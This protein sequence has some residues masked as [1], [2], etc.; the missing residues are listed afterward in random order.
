VKYVLIGGQAAVISGA[1]L[2]TFDFDACYAR[3]TDNLRRL[4]AALRDLHARL[5]V[6][7]MSD[8]EAEDLPF[9]IDETTLGSGLNFTFQ[10][11]A[12]AVD[13]LGLPAGV[14]GYEELIANAVAREIGGQVVQVASIRDLISMKQASGREKDL[15][16]LPTLL[17]LLDRLDESDDH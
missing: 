17:A 4:A 3:D 2:F 15:F 12:G 9:H 7:K 1:P 8:E 10:T 14:S 6:A 11:R 16:A 5:R 13:V